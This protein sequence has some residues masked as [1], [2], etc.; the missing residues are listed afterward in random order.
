MA[1]SNG[2]DFT[3]QVDDTTPT[4][5]DISN[6]VTNFEF[7]T[8][9]NL[10]EVTGVDKSAMERIA[11]L[12]DFSITLNGVH[13]PA[14]NASFDVFK[15]LGTVRTVTLT[16][17]DSDVLTNECLFEEFGY[18]RSDEGEFTWSASGLLADGTIPQWA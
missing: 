18:E 1:K 17:T 6:D 8:P 10:L 4:L 9:L 3:V 5:R 15:T 13:N 7:A 11:G 2:L 16:T 14:S 12:A